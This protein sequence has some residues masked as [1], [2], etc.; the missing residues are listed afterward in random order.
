MIKGVCTANVAHCMYMYPSHRQCLH[1]TRLQAIA[2]SVYLLEVSRLSGG[3]QIAAKHG[4]NL[5][6]CVCVEHSTVIHL[7]HIQAQV[8][9]MRGLCK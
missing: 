4:Y 7:P 2:V 5:R 9:M 1:E 3:I 8:D 6:V